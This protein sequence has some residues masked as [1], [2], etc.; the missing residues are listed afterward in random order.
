MNTLET[1]KKRDNC[2]FYDPKK[3]FAVIGSGSAAFAFAIR[4][5][6]NGARITI[7]EKEKN[8]GGTC[9]NVGCVPSKILIQAAHNAQEHRKNPFDGIK[10]IQPQIDR[11]LL[12]EQISNRVDE[13]R[14]GKYEDI[15]KNNSSIKLMKGTAEFE[16][17]DELIINLPDGKK[18]KL[19]VDGV[20][21]A[22]GS[23]AVIPKIPGLLE[24]PF[25]TSTEALFTDKM[26]EHL[27]V[28]GS[29]VV[30]VELAQAF[31]RLGSE[32][33]ILARHTLLY[34]NDPDLGCGLKSVF[35]NEGIDVV[36]NAVIEKISHKENEFTIHLG[37]TELNCDRLLIAAGRTSNTAALNLEKANVKTD[38][39]GSIIVDDRMQTSNP[40]IYAAGDCTSGPKYVYVAA[41]GGTRAG[42]NITG[43]N[44][45]LD[46]AVLPEVIFT[47]P[48]IAMVGLTLE[49]A[50]ELNIPA[51]ER[52]LD[53]ENVPRALANF[54]TNGFIKL[55]RNTSNDRLIGAQI[56]APQAGEMIQ[57]VSLALKNEMTVKEISNMLFPYLTMAEGIKLCAMTFSK[58]VKQ[59]SCCAG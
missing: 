51:D 38:L 20:F 21:I 32:V 23:S 56:L 1:K 55:I 22:T 42:D 54:E 41:A 15:L 10:D 24:T 25:W 2:P 52:K 49:Q 28:I 9:V 14:L 27:V 50:Q 59:L 29:S 46:L 57:I 13:M 33:T 37:D 5:A 53:L 3:H 45:T 11:K 43:G 16:T 17:Q 18:D 26:P 34:K 36:E 39:N 44:S 19:F 31:R 40:T 58:D 4:A 8:I 6:E 7:V 48:Q 12:L 30:A 35:E 47:D